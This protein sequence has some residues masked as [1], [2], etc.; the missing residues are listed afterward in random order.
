MRK[1][2]GFATTISLRTIPVIIHWWWTIVAYPERRDRTWPRDWSKTPP[3]RWLWLTHKERRPVSQNTPFASS[4]ASK[5][6]TCWNPLYTDPINFESLYW[7]FFLPISRGFVINEAGRSLSPV[8]LVMFSNPDGAAIRS[9]W[10][11][12]MSCAMTNCR[13]L[14]HR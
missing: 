14:F 9:N 7:T 13:S 1:S 4:N 11:N 10:D 5:N 2:I 6:S 8:L 3:M 12:F